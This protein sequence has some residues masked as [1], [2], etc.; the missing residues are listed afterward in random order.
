VKK[1]YLNA[2]FEEMQT[3]YG[4]IEEYCSEGLGTDAAQQK[5]LRDLY[6][7]EKSP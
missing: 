2:A 5:A 4:T 7:G 1:E 6:V 3:K